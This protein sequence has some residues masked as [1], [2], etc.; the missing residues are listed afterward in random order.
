M[1]LNNMD[2]KKIEFQALKPLSGSERICVDL[3]ECERRAK[4]K[5][6]KRKT[7]QPATFLCSAF[8]S[9]YSEDSYGGN[10]SKTAKG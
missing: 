9:K 7:K 2:K 10:Q 3:G 4:S 6:P 1:N 5:L 8:L